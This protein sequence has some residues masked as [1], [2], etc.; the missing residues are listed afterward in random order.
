MSNQQD[1]YQNLRTT[2]RGWLKNEEGKSNKWAEYLMCAPD[3]FHLICKLAIDPEILVADKAK[4][5]GVIVYF[6]SPVDLIPEALIGPFGYVDDIALTAYV[7]NGIITH[8]DPSIIQKHWAGE[9]DVLDLIQKILA[10][11]D[12]MVGGLWVKLKRQFK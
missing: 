2:I 6:I 3:L 7:L 1:F 9:G 10:V 8:T 11:A 12:E 5:A 4:L